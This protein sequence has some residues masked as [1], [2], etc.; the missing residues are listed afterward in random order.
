[1]VKRSV[2]FSCLT[3]WIV[4]QRLNDIGEKPLTAISAK[5][6]RFTTIFSLRFGACRSRAK[7][8]PV[9]ILALALIRR[10]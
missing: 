4:S 6:A 3:Q 8:T 9:L 7:Q 5:A 1:V 10:R 2:A